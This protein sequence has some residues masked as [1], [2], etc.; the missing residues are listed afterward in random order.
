MTYL[1]MRVKHHSDIVTISHSQLLT[2]DWNY[3]IRAVSEK[4]RTFGRPDYHIII[5]TLINNALSRVVMHV[6]L[7]IVAISNAEVFSI[8]LTRH[9]IQELIFLLPKEKLPIG[10]FLSFLL[11]VIPRIGLR[12]RRL[13]R[14]SSFVHF[15]ADLRCFVWRILHLNIVTIHCILV[16]ASLKA[17]LAISFFADAFLKRFKTFVSHFSCFKLLIKFKLSKA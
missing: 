17:W 7:A 12:L 11:R 6:E 4:N 16:F 2:K 14:C 8:E 1:S 13:V 9:S 5:L 3:A 15:Q 10:G